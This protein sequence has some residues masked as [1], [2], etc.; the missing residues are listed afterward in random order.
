MSKMLSGLNLVSITSELCR[1]RPLAGSTHELAHLPLASAPH[2]ADRVPHLAL[3]VT[4]VGE[5]LALVGVT[6][7]PFENA[8]ATH[9]AYLPHPVVEL[10]FGRAGVVLGLPLALKEAFAVVLAVVPL[11]SVAALALVED[12]V[13]KLARLSIL[14]VPQVDLLEYGP[15]F[16]S[17]DGD[18]ASAIGL[19]VEFAAVV[20]RA[21]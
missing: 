6:A 21:I 18:E 19:S 9:V 16:I 17:E 8:V 10:D 12:Q 1:E 15:L 13:P 20:D 7:G 5:P 4:P 3:P 11:A 2:T 14:E